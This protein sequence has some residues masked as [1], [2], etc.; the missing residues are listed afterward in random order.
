M[1]RHGLSYT[2][3]ALTD[4]V[5]V[6]SSPASRAIPFT[7]DVSINVTNTGTLTGSEVVQVYVTLPDI[8]LTTPSLQLRGFTKVKDL[9]PGQTKTATV[10][11]TAATVSLASARM[12]PTEKSVRRVSPLLRA[13]TT[14]SDSHSRISSPWTTRRP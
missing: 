12:A 7:L 1:C 5:L 2:T 14:F 8:G 13:T 10:S 11:G 6:V 3:F 9:Q 4:L